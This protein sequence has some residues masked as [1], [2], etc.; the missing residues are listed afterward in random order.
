MTLGEV[1]EHGSLKRSCLI[2]ELTSN[3]ETERRNLNRYREHV[4]TLTVERDRWRKNF[5]LSHDECFK[6]R[7][8]AGKLAKA[9]EEHLS[10]QKDGWYPTL[11]KALS[12]YAAMG[13]GETK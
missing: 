1:C 8:L 13:K 2:C 7:E 6:W 12:L 3:L 5:Q 4:N 11:S 9:V 10:Y